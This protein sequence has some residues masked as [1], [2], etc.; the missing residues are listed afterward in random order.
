[1]LAEVAVAALSGSLAL[2]AD[3]GHMLVD[4]GAIGA[5]V[6]ATHLAERPA[7]HRW[8]Y[9]LKRAEIIAAAVNGVTLLVAA[10]LILVE[11]VRRLVHPPAVD[12][13]ALVVVATV[14]I[15]VNLAATLV[16]GHA[17][18]DSLNIEGAFQHM[19][20]DLFAFVGTAVAGIVILATGYDRADAIASIVM[21]GH[22]LLEGT[23]QAVDLDEVR[24]HHL[25]LPEVLS[26]HDLHAWTVTSSLPI[27]S[28]H[29]VIDDRCIAEGAAAQVLD[30]LQECLA[31][32]FDVEHSTL[33]LEPSTHADH[34]R[35]MHD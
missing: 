13:A 12:G 15:A 22:V 3:A 19:V 2:L 25:E 26:V 16:L 31:G 24:R 11:G 14:G 30:H 18:R 23:P 7:S 1:M 8:T 34:E 10:A 9:G 27:L 20:T 21:S 29:V 35:A 32:H 17:D 4:A 28:A 33:Q 5:S 6:W